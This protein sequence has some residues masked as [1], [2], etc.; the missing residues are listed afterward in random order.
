MV[1]PL[2][3]PLGVAFLKLR[4]EVV[5]PKVRIAHRGLDGFVAG[6]ALGGDKVARRP[7]GFCHGRVAKVVDP[8]VRNA[9]GSG[10]PF[11]LAIEGAVRDRVALAAHRAEP[12]DRALGDVGEDGVGVQPNVAPADVG[13]GLGQRDFDEP[14]AG[15]P[16]LTRCCAVIVTSS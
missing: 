12:G 11:E 7:E 3:W 10:G 13:H 1:W 16:G 6:E 9:D 4:P 8:G 5:G 2:L 15:V 14:A